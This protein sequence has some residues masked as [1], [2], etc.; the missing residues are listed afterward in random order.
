MMRAFFVAAFGAALLPAATPNEKAPSPAPPAPSDRKAPV[1]LQQASAQRNENVF[2]SR[3]DTNAVKELNIRMGDNV[4][5]IPQPPVELSHYATEHGRPPGESVTLRPAPPVSG[6]HGEL[7][8]TLRNSAFNART[9]FQ[10]GPVLPSRM[11]QYGGRFTGGVRGL[12]S[13]SGNLSQRKIRGMVNGNILAPLASERTPLAT[14]PEVRALVARFL[15]AYPDRLPNRPDFDPRALNTNSP[16]TIDET[17][18]SLRLDRQAGPQG[19]L[20]LLHSI[21][22]QRVHAFQLVA[23]QNPDTDIHTHRSRI[24][25]TLSPAPETN[26]AIG[27]AFHRARSLLQPEP[28][29]V[30]PRVRMGYQIEELGPDS[31]FPID[32]AINTWRYGALATH[33]TGAAH[34]LTFGGDFARYQLNGIETFNQRGL[35]IFSSNFGRTAIE[36]LR[37]GTPTSY[38]VSLGEVSRGFRNSE[39]NLFF[40]GR[41]KANGRL[42]LYYGLRYN[43]VT[44]PIEVNRLNTIPYG[45]D[46]NNFSPRFSFSGRLT[47]ATIVRGG[48]T[49]SF[50][51]ILPVTYQQIRYNAPLVRN[52]QIANPDLL[53]PLRDIDLNGANVRSSP[54][55]LSPDLVSPYSHQYNLSV[56]RRFQNQYLLR[57]GY[58]GS[59]SFKLLNSYVQNRAEPTPGIPLTTETVNLRRPDPNFYEIKHIVNGGIAYMDAAQVELQAPS[60]RGLAWGFSYTFGKSIDEGA[61]YTSTA[62]NRDQSRARSQWQYDSFR[63]R[64]GLSN[65]DSR[66]AFLAYYSYNLPRLGRLLSGW[67]I[68]GSTLV[69]AG[70]PITLYVGSDA[71]GYGNVDGG[72]SDRPNLV[73][74]SILGR[75]ISHPNLAPAILSRD[76][77]AYIRPGEKRGSL[78]RGTFR[79]AGIA[80]FN[81]ALGREWRWGGGRERFLQFRAEAFNLA[82]HPQFDEPQRN[83]NAQAFGKITNTLNDGRVLQFGLRLSL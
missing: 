29:A 23:G 81:A 39:G 32:R 10:V 48:Y 17:D 35:Y 67:Q 34:E 46:C 57:A 6:W 19:K 27:A 44:A 14:H 82:N 66:H 77:F 63:D 45:C 80:N 15:A 73:D 12:G 55:I 22:R 47:A 42:E 43:L 7:F 38:E 64:K 9:F 61:D 30:G 78:G 59:R 54:T 72:S 24:A 16:Q 33:Q 37:L 53:S 1:Q 51:Q 36:N 11:N 70:T 3:I 58:L 18:A 71:P 8:E 25:Y 79:R 41:W 20:S 69:K 50:G 56:E 68:S 31:E 21:G 49:V 65:F 2:F 5:L 4:T 75:T 60:R 26:I 76:R 40:A 13:L 83:L 52:I 28:N 74:P 62:A